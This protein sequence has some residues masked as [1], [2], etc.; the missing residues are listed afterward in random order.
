ME[1][2]IGRTRSPYGSISKV[3]FAL[4][5]TS[6]ANLREPPARHRASAGSHGVPASETGG[7]EDAADDR[8][9]AEACNRLGSQSEKL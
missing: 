7:L 8:T 1:L 2:K 9:D 4:T 5:V 6:S 3:N